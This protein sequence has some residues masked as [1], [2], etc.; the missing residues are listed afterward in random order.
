MSY[1]LNDFLG[2]IEDPYDDSSPYL[3][4]AFR[5][6]IIRRFQRAVLWLRHQYP[7]Q[8]D[9]KVLIG[10]TRN[11][12][13]AAAVEALEDGGKFFLLSRGLLLRTVVLAKL[14]A[15]V[16]RTRGTRSSA[17]LP[18]DWDSKV[19][20]CHPRERAFEDDHLEGPLMEALVDSLGLDA[21][22]QHHA[23][24]V[25]AR[26]VVFAI[27]HEAAH[28]GFKHHGMEDDATA[29]ELR[30][31]EL[32]ADLFALRH[33]LMFHGFDFR[34]S[35]WTDVFPGEHG[36]VVLSREEVMRHS[37]RMA[38]LLHT[39]QVKAM[40]TVAQSAWIL[41]SALPRE[42]GSRH[43]SPAARWLNLQTMVLEPNNSEDWPCLAFLWGLSFAEDVIQ[44]EGGA[45][46]GLATL[47][48][49]ETEVSK[50]LGIDAQAAYHLQMRCTENAEFPGAFPVRYGEH[51][52]RDAGDVPR[53]DDQD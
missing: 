2:D 18:T 21:E 26:A 11:P 12:K 8:F 20:F 7:K 15:T 42:P 6:L 24:D 37:E 36:V 9:H 53:D 50:A 5:E 4:R 30:G 25:A 34:R 14:V 31:L 3:P 23:Y 39:P 28:V 32:Q 27:F 17:I 40:H 19:M 45:A 1:R 16:R 13:A 33:A 49:I 35:P 52:V 46:A 41:F 44:L 29:P 22:Q 47:D 51:I 43:L 48:T 10:I 38:N